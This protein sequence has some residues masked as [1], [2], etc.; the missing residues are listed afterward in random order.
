MSDT[1][2]NRVDAYIEESIVGETSE[3]TAAVSNSTLQSLPQIQVSG[4]QGKLLYLLAR[5]QGAR[6][7]L[8]IGTLGGYSTIWLAKALPPDGHLV[9]LE[10]DP[11]HVEVARENI[12][13]AG[14]EN[15][16]QIRIGP[17]LET[18]S[19]LLDETTEPFDLF[20]IDADKQSNADYF[21]WALRFSRPGSLIIVD[22]VIREGAVVDAKTTHSAVLGTRR[23][24]ETV[25]AEPRVE[26]TAIQTVGT[27]GY[28]G[29]LLAR[30]LA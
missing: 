15:L 25:A 3:L 16:V 8:E 27:K 1:L 10:M 22:N 28:D 6:H 24:Y 17:A 5:L 11:H 18:L 12:V 4:A 2:W 14:L 29:F 7:I 26:A 9:T 21:A 30:V 13:A 19:L 20:F 23:L